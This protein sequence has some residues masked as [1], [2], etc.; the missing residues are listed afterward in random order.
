MG[1]RGRGRLL[2]GIEG[3]RDLDLGVG[4]KAAYGPS[5]HH[6]LDLVHTTV[7][8]DGEPIVLTDWKLARK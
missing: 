7:L 4:M 8:R 3:I 2:T 6:A 1:M 5:R